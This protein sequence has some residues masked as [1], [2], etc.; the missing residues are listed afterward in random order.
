[1][2]F[3]DMMLITVINVLNLLFLHFIVSNLF[4]LQVLL[5]PFRYV[6]QVPGKMIRGKLAQAFNYWMKIPEEKLSAISE[7]TLMLH[8]ASLLWVL[9]WLL[10]PNSLFYSLIWVVTNYFSGMFINT[11]PTNFLD[12]DFPSKT[13]AILLI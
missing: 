7:I 6:L 12:C 11:M 1:M 5:Q 8:N 2:L 13:L 3:L 4:S 10:D 9:C